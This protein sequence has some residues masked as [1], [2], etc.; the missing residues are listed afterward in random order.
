MSEFIQEKSKTPR[1]YIVFRRTVNK[2]QRKRVA[3]GTN[4]VTQLGEHEQL[5]RCELTDRSGELSTWATV[6]GMQYYVAKGYVP[7]ELGQFE[8]FFARKDKTQDMVQELVGVFQTFSRSVQEGNALQA[9]IKEREDLLARLA[10]LEAKSVDSADLEAE[11]ARLEAEAAAKVEAEAKARE[12][13]EAQ[14]AKLVA[15]MEELK[16]ALA[17]QKKAAAAA[18][19]A[20][21]K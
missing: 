3:N 20:A 4:E 12:H 18:A 1:P 16:T 2:G 9:A 10:E 11:K 13:A 7:V 17:E 8:E 21:N 15:E 6:G 14:N 19:K 5:W